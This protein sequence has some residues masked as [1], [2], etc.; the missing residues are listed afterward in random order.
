MIFKFYIFKK[1]LLT[2]IYNVGENFRKFIFYGLFNPK[3]TGSYI[4]IELD[5]TKLNFYSDL[6]KYKVN[7]IEIDNYKIIIDSHKK[8]EIQYFINNKVYVMNSY[9][10]FYGK[11]SKNKIF[12]NNIKNVL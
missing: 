7:D 10:P 11:T 4:S 2:Q 8:L 3:K 12:I 1:L 9:V 6:R 5:I